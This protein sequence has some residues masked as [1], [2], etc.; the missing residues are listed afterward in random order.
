MML[1]AI[2]FDCDGVLADN[3]STWETIHEHFGTDNSDTLELFLSGKVSE[4]EFIEEDIG[5]WKAVQTNIHRDDIMRCFAGTS[6]MEG[7]RDVVTELQ[8]RGIF[9][10]IVSSGVDLCVGAI[11]NMLEVDDWVA[12]GF[13]WDDEG[14]MVGGAPVRVRSHQKG[15]M[16]QKMAKINGFETDKIVCVGDS[17]TDLSM[18]IGASRFIGFNPIRESSRTAFR[19]AEVDIV[20]GRDLR[21]IWPQLFPDEDSFP[22]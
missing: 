12:N 8:R 17:G 18:C 22:R 7:A 6:L 10:A 21:C 14:W 20:E 9:V 2:A 13:V 5:K 3:G 11:A 19:A 1:R 15:L 4:E 16:V